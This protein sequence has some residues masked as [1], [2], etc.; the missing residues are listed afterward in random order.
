MLIT[1]SYLEMNRT[2]HERDK[3]FGYFGGRYCDRLLVQLDKRG[4]R[5]VL[6]YG[7]GKGPV[8]DVLSRKAQRIAVYEYDPAIA[9]KDSRPDPRDAVCCLDVMEHIEPECM[10][11]VLDD[12]KGLARKLVYFVICTQLSGSHMLPDGRN[13]HLIVQPFTWW[14]EHLEKRWKLVHSEDEMSKN[15]V[16]ICEP[17]E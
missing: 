8:K 2:V 7:A 16:A 5:E 14:K 9:G 12:I 15:F 4:I 10:D 11:E 17:H 6:D 1:D 3:N 13:P